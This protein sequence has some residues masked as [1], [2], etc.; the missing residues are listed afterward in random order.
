MRL[1]PGGGAV[2]V[3]EID[4]LSLRDLPPRP[5]R[6]QTLPGSRDLSSFCPRA[7]RALLVRHW[8][9]YRRSLE[10]VEPG[11]APRQL[12]IGTPGPGGHGLQPRRRAGLGAARG[13]AGRPALTLMALDRRGSV[14]AGSA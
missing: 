7:G 3:P 1:L 9:D 6:R 13:R 14:L 4:G 5:P 8:P 2:V 12:W 10:L 11:L